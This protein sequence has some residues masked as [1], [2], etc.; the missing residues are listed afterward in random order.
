MN[1]DQALNSSHSFYMAFL[2]SMEERP[3]SPGKFQLLLVPAVV[4]AAFSIEL[5]FK[6][7]LLRADKTI[8]SH[9]LETIFNNLSLSEQTA[10]VAALGLP[11]AQ[12]RKEL[13]GVANA[14][15]DWRYIYEQNDVTIDIAFLSKLADVTQS[16]L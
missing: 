11:E 1:I 7:L 4:C 15:E 2:R 6:V 9:D 3:I 14:F 8:K 5:G 13:V 10:L 16:I 12:F